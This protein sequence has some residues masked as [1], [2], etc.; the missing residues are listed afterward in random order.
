MFTHLNTIEWDF[1]LKS[2][3]NENLNYF[4]NKIDGQ[5]LAELKVKGGFE[6]YLCTI[7]QM[8][9]D[10]VGNYIGCV[11]S[12]AKCGEEANILVY[13]REHQRD[14]VLSL[15]NDKYL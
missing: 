15:D 4:S 11:K 2:K 14:K 6:Y 9:N 8:N 7:V 1:I 3:K 10:V 13:D 12:D 5:I